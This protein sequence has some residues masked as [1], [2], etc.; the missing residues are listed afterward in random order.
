MP[1]DDIFLAISDFFNIIL[2]KKAVRFLE[3]LV[4]NVKQAHSGIGL[5]FLNFIFQTLFGQG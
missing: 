3:L 5:H 4:Y 1:P 2:M